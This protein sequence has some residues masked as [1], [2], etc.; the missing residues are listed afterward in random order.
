MQIDA[1]CPGLV[2]QISDIQ[3][4]DRSLISQESEV[5]T[6][7]GGRNWGLGQGVHYDMP[8]VKRLVFFSDRR[9]ATHV[10]LLTIDKWIGIMYDGQRAVN[11][12]SSKAD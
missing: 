4:S 12:C 7:I 5:R 10:F 11:W 1:V 3:I 2:W 8:P 9:P 6:A